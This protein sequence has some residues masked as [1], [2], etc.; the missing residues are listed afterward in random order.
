M[1]NWRSKAAA[2]V[3]VPVL[4]VTAAACGEANDG[5]GEG[6]LSGSIR[7]DGSSTLGPLT[8]AAAELFRDENGGVDVSVGTSGTGGGFEKFCA[9]ETDISDASRP[10]KDEEIELCK[11][12]KVEYAELQVANDALTVMVHKDNPVN[13]LTVEQLKQIWEPKSKVKSWSEIKGLKEKFGEKLELYGPGTDSGTFEY[14]T[15]EINGEKGEQ[16]ADYND[17]GEKDNEGITGVS[18]TT[19]GMFYA[20]FSY[21]E[22]N[23]DKLKALEIDGGDGCVAP[24][25]ETVQDGSYKPLGRPLFIYPSKKALEEK[26]V[27]GFVDF[28]LE[29]HSKIS[30]AV[31]FVPMTDEQAAKSSETLAS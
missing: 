9:G 4:A 26:H 15:E 20:G 21:F 6:G 18:G 11:K 2:L 3:A 22:E 12:G 25:I 16:R 8:S 5:G 29:N 7:I 23:K 31:G 14:F 13:C 28:Y 27:K 19:G 10:I 30:E 17:I 1:H 24:S